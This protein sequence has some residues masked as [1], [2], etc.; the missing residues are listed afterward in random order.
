MRLGASKGGEK[1]VKNV[2]FEESHSAG[3]TPAPV[4]TSGL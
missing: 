4:L 3:K 2:K 1:M